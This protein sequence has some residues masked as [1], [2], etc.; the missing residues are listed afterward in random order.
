M[1]DNSNSII[2]DFTKLN[3]D[4]LE[5]WL[6]LYASAMVHNC[7]E[8]LPEAFIDFVHSDTKIMARLNAIYFEARQNPDL[9]KSYQMTVLYKNKTHSQISVPKDIIVS[10]KRSTILG[11]AASLL[12]IILGSLSLYLYDNSQT[13]LSENLVLNSKIDSLNQVLISVRTERLNNE[14]DKPN[15]SEKEPLPVVDNEDFF[16][17][18]KAKNHSAFQPDQTKELMIADAFASRGKN[19]PTTEN[20]FTVKTFNPPARATNEVAFHWEISKNEQKYTK[21]VYFRLY[22]NQK[23]LKEIPLL[24]NT[25]RLTIADGLS[26]GLYY[27]TLE[28]E[29]QQIFIGKFDFFVK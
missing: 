5:A 7:V 26:T 1:K 8:D 27:W 13:K 14:I 28:T 11:I 2:P 12:I 23:K 17:A 22:N 20:P 18:Q 15:T 10:S 9:I 16:V 24:T 21:Q 3:S 19:E 29:D 25:Y 4:Q 6:S